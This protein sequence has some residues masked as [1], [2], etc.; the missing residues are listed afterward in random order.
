MCAKLSHRN[1]VTFGQTLLI[2]GLLVLRRTNLENENSNEVDKEA[3]DGHD[4]EPLV[5]HFWRF[6]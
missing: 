1:M 2:E 4:Q 6:N 5:F 3:Q